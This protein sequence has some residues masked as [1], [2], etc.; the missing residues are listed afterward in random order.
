MRQWGQLIFDYEP[1]SEWLEDP[2]LHI[3]KKDQ[4]IVQVAT[5]VIGR[6]DV[7]AGVPKFNH[8]EKRISVQ[9][10]AAGDALE[11]KVVTLITHPL[12]QGQ[13][14][15]VYDFQPSAVSEEEL[16]IDIANGRAV[17]VKASANIEASETRDSERQ[18][19]RWRSS[20]FT[21]GNR[22]F[23]EDPSRTSPDVQLTSFASWEEVGRWYADIERSQRV[24]TQEIRQR[25]TD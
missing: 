4:S 25:R 6:R 1:F 2:Y 19:Y 15:V 12:A 7:P 13:F 18:I 5:E 20:N 14:W 11:Y 10:L 3:V 23:K 8:D 21:P 24:P 17:K 9:G 16:E 22:Q